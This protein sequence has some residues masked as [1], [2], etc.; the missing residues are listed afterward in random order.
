MHA[1]YYAR[2][3]VSGTIHQFDGLGLQFAGLRHVEVVGLEVPPGCDHGICGN[4]WVDRI[5]HIQASE[6]LLSFFR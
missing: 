6:L 5:F 3:T 1:R 4:G 2:L